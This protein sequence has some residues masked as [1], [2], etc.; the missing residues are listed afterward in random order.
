MNQTPDPLKHSTATLTDDITAWYA[1]GESLANLGLHNEA[2]ACF[3]KI[4]ATEPTH[5]NSWVFRGVELL[6]LERYTDAL[7]SCDRAIAL[8]SVNTEAWTFRGVALQRLKRYQ[9]AYDSY[10]RAIDLE[11][12]PICDSLWDVL[13]YRLQRQIHSLTLWWRLAFRPPQD[14]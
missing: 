2:L 10:Q 8:N 4:L 14:Y 3:D 12:V 9:D 7:D 13:S 11:C 6:H 5:V 1:R